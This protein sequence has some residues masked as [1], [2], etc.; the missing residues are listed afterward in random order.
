MTNNSDFSRRDFLRAGA[1][2]ATGLA[3]L[4]MPGSLDAFSPPS[5]T[6]T[7][8]LT[9]RAFLYD[10]N[11]ATFGAWND[12]RADEKRMSGERKRILSLLNPKL[13]PFLKLENTGTR[14]RFYLD[15]NTIAGHAD[16]IVAEVKKNGLSAFKRQG[17]VYFNPNSTSGRFANILIDDNLKA[18]IR[19]LSTAYT[20][21][22]IG[23]TE[24]FLTEDVY[25]GE[26]PESGEIVRFPIRFLKFA[27]RT[28]MKEGVDYHTY[29]LQSGQTLHRIAST[30]TLGDYGTN[31]EAVLKFNSIEPSEIN[32]LSEGVNILIPNEIHRNPLQPI[33]VQKKGSGYIAVQEPKPKT[34]L[35][36]PEESAET[37]TREAEV[38]RAIPELTDAS[39]Y[40][41]DVIPQNLMVL[42][43]TEMPATLMEAF[44]IRNAK[45]RKF[46]SNDSNLRGLAHAY[47]KGILSYLESNPHVTNIIFDNGHG[48]GDMGAPDNARNPTTYEG[49]F[50][51]KIFESLR[52]FLREEQRERNFR[53]FA[54][55]YTGG[56]GQTDRLRWYVKEANRINQEVGGKDNSAYV[57]IHVNSAR[58][59]FEPPP[60][61]RVHGIGPQPKS[62]ELGAHILSY[63]VPFYEKNF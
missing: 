1:V 29:N 3:G 13:K 41:D 33:T 26:D 27:L 31:L 48:K 15:L 23:A 20:K 46:Y 58:P 28:G 35:E 63:A 14:H 39:K 2:A 61:S 18:T 59:D 10:V 22:D 30:Y 50:T 7:Q 6:Q 38:R 17:L 40:L 60:E 24:D 16:R 42:G 52:D 51:R 34:P 8:G 4:L 9:Q 5:T 44:N 62:T 32:S 43:Q 57:S 36:T 47:G 56:G 54:L 37:R 49:D 12:K 25:G 11:L 21:K 19:E 55:N 45:Q 53:I